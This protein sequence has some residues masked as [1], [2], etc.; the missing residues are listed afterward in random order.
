[1]KVIAL[2]VGSVLLV[3]GVEY[4]SARILFPDMGLGVPDFSKFLVVTLM[5]AV[6]YTVAEIVKEASR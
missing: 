3:T 2:F 4:I 6:V 1:V 5:F